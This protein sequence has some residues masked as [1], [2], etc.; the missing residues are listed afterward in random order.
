M[1]MADGEQ[2]ERSLSLVN[3]TIDVVFD[4]APL[5][6]HS[7][8]KD[9]TIVR[10]NR[11]W[12]EN[13]GYKR[14][15]V[16]GR[17][18]VEFL[19]DES[20]L[21][22]VK[23][24]LPLF[25]RVGSA[26]S[27]GYQFVPKNGRVFNVLLDAEVSSTASGHLFSYAAI[28]EAH[29]LTQWEQ[30]SNTIRALQRLTRLRRDL[31]GAVIEGGSVH[32]DLE[33]PVLQQSSAHSLE[34][35]WGREATAGLLELAQD[36]SVNLRGLLRLQEEWQETTAEQQRELLMVAKSID[37]T[38]RDLSDYVATARRLSQ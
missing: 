36:I 1:R 10:V 33:L 11:R 29:D 13:L 18:A 3:Q 23:D 19:T 7:L 31:E 14:D 28:R 2:T 22:A 15:K 17:K 4:R 37:R 5:M 34:E 21:R 6:M 20:R 30:A 26:R 12:L 24:T 8:N 25:W 32:S 27:V 35:D 38:L 16:L 9:G